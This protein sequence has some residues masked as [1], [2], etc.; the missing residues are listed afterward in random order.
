MKYFSY[1]IKVLCAFILVIN[2]VF[3]QENPIIVEKLYSDTNSSTFHITIKDSVSLHYHAT[4][5]ENIFV[6]EGTA[7]MQLGNKIRVLQKGDYLTI[8]PNIA[9]AVWVTS[10]IPLRVI[11]IQSPEFK[12]EDRYYINNE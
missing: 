2:S 12:G 9:H 3:A 8:P 7:S 4:H 5:T 6:L 10:N 11:S 1:T